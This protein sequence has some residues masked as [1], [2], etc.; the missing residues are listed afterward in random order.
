MG[1]RKD[2]LLI[3]AQFGHAPP[4][5]VRPPWAKESVKAADFVGE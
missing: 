4:K 5:K 3:Y 2:F 1:T